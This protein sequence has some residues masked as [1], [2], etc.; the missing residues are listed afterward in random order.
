LIGTAPGAV[1]V[2]LLSTAFKTG[3]FT[4]DWV[5]V[6]ATL[7]EGDGLFLGGIVFATFDFT[8]ALTTGFFTETGAL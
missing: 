1:A 2:T 6:F 5:F 7:F 8:T 4:G 3:E